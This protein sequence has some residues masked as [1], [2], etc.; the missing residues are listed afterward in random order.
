MTGAHHKCGRS[1]ACA[2]PCRD[3]T[4][5]LIWLELAEAEAGESGFAAHV[6]RRLAAGEELYGARWAQL[7]L[8]RLVDELAEEAA[9]LGSWGVLALEAL[10]NEPDIDPAQR[11]LIATTLHAAILWGAYA[12]N[13]LTIARGHLGNCPQ[14]ITHA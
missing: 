13:A 2:W 8:A 14:G 1:P 12:H 6:R 4:L 11:E 7:G 5:E 10:E 9:D 3:E